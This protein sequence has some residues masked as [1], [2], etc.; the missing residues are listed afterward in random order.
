MKKAQSLA[1]QVKAL[2]AFLGIFHTVKRS[3]IEQ[4]M[5]G[6]DAE[7][8]K[9]EEANYS[10]IEFFGGN[11][12]KLYDI[13]LPILVNSS[14]RTLRITKISALKFIERFKIWKIRNRVRSLSNNFEYDR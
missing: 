12:I 6:G 3:L 10:D 13:D 1:D 2:E 5:N 7:E 8:D 11:V 9:D 14:V 4:L